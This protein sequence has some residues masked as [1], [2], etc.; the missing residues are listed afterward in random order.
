MQKEQ[1][2]N[3]VRSILR[4]ELFNVQSVEEKRKS[5]NQI[6][7]TGEITQQELSD[8]IRENVKEQ[9]KRI[10]EMLSILD[11]F[12]RDE[13]IIILE[14]FNY[15]DFLNFVLK[16]DVK[17]KDLLALCNT[18]KK[19][20]EYCNKGLEVKNNNGDIVK[21][22]NQ[23]LFRLLLSK[24]KITT[25]PNYKTPKELYI[26]KTIGGEVLG[27]GFNDF[28]QLGFRKELSIVNPPATILDQIIQVSAGTNRSLCLDNQGKVWIFGDIRGFV[29]EEGDED[30]DG[31]LLISNLSNIIYISCGISSFCLDD[32]GRVWSFGNNTFGQLGLGD[33]NDRNTP[34]LVP[35][36]NN[37]IQV[38]AK[39]H[40]T[41]CLDNQGNVWSFGLNELQ[42]LGLGHNN[43]NRNVPTQIDNLQNIVKIST[44]VFHSLCLDDQGHVWSFGSNVDGVLGLGDQDDRAVPTMI[45]T[46]EN[47]IDI[48][49]G[50]DHSLC[51]DN[52]GRVWGFGANE[53][54]EDYPGQLGPENQRSD[55]P[56]LIPN[57]T[58][59][60]QISAGDHY[61]LCLDNQGRVWSFGSNAFGRLGLDI[62]PNVDIPTLIPT[63]NNV[64]QISAGNI[65]SLVIRKQ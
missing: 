33:E 9:E 5:L 65:H 61:S 32:Q 54:G 11:N 58:N 2:F 35:G 53:L 50:T 62:Y 28:S 43:I 24:M 20:Q 46:L 4:S 38:S 29:V 57:L 13:M 30:I 56:I 42:Q 48:S 17:G 23:Y 44:G 6:L 59:I 64:F 52:Q 34:T 26:E 41:L 31:P 7:E 63:L 39:A 55:F 49:A 8:L 25:I 16:G 36:L 3:F 21:F 51:L 18:S 40:H 1:V 27:F 60:I 14:K 22:D 45:P 12:N 19:F 47:I 10:N 15:N 37:I